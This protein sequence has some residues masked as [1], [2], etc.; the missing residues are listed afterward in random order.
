[1]TYDVNTIMKFMY[2]Y[3]NGEITKYITFTSGNNV[4]YI[5]LMKQC[6][7][8]LFSNMP[9]KTKIYTFITFF[10]CVKG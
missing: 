8:D 3:F 4:K 5:V 6:V 9:A 2:K 1:M 7:F 10:L